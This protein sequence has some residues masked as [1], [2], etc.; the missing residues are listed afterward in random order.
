MTLNLKLCSIKGDGLLSARE[1]HLTKERGE[2]A[3][4]RGHHEKG[5]VVSSSQSGPEK[6]WEFAF[7]LR[8]E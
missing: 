4:G 1:T 5:S 2:F 6:A 7:F 3:G 8:Q